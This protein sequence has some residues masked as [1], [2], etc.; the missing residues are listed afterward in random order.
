MLMS[1]PHQTQRQ[2]QVTYAMSSHL[3]LVPTVLDWFSIPYPATD[4]STN[5]PITPLP[6]K[7]LL[8][9]LIKGKKQGYNETKIANEI[10]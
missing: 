6:G 7:S 3:D 8:P 4:E 10:L 1:S 5:S 9:L 2:Y